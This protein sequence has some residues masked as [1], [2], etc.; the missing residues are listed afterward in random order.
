MSL[1]K[2]L[3]TCCNTEILKAR[4]IVVIKFQK[5][6]RWLIVSHCIQALYY[7]IKSLYVFNEPIINVQILRNAR[8]LPK[9]HT[10]ILWIQ[11]QSS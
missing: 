3:W 10:N 9:A 6:K 4:K 5:L 2:N 11:F 8:T 1:K 7:N